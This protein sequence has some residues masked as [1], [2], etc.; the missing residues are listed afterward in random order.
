MPRTEYQ[1]EELRINDRKKTSTAVVYVIVNIWLVL[2][3]MYL[4]KPVLMVYSVMFTTVCLLYRLKQLQRA[5]D[6]LLATRYDS[7]VYGNR[8]E[9]PFDLEKYIEESIRE[10]NQLAID[11]SPSRVDLASDDRNDENL[12]TEASFELEIN[13]QTRV[14]H[15]ARPRGPHPAHPVRPNPHLGQM[16]EEPDIFDGELHAEWSSDHEDTRDDLDTLRRN[17]RDLNVVSFNRVSQPV[18]LCSS[19]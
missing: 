18:P 13:D 1:R 9:T 2:V 8:E 16:W 3:C 10:R 14:R 4:Q 12:P 11:D 5:R 15:F 7:S 6:L 17:T 19:L